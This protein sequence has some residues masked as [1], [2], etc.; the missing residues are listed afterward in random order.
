MLSQKFKN[1]ITC[2]LNVVTLRCKCKHLIAT[3]EKIS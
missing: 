3:A 2:F 1:K